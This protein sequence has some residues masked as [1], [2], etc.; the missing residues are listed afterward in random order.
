MSISE[1][2]TRLSLYIRSCLY[3]K[4]NLA[5]HIKS[6]QLIISSS[7]FSPPSTSLQCKTLVGNVYSSLSVGAIYRHGYEGSYWL[8]VYFPT[9]G[10]FGVTILKT[11]VIMGLMGVG[12]Y[13]YFLSR[14]LSLITHPPFIRV[15]LAFISLLFLYLLPPEFLF[16]LYWS[17]IGPH[18]NRM[19]CNFPSSAGRSNCS[20]IFLRSF[21]NNLLYIILMIIFLW[22]VPL[23]I[24]DRLSPNLSSSSFLSKSAPPQ[25]HSATYTV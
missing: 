5:L 19:V 1:V 11:M 24:S 17:Q 12:I 20:L 9:V 16:D 13:F 18:V 7:V 25:A 14:R 6:T 8:L 22:R 3:K 10:L 21:G 23:L 4:K 15:I 2:S